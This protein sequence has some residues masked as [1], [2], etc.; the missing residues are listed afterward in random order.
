MKALLLF[1]LIACSMQVNAQYLESN[2]YIK[3]SA[4]FAQDFPGLNGYGFSGE[5]SLPLKDRL[6]GAIGLR[7]L[8]MQGFPRTS[9][10]QEF[11]KA[12]SIDFNL[13]YLPLRTDQH[14][15][16]VG[17]GYSFVVYKTR[18]SY[19][20]MN[21]GTDKETQWPVKDLN[22]RGSGLSLLGE[23]EYRLANG[24]LSLGLRAAWVKAYD[25]AFY[26][27]PFAAIAL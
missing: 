10:V 8:Q 18:R 7:H 24:P 2:R 4:G 15:L 17:A 23:Y 5:F 1:L 9:T 6:E 11:T 13:Y 3:I 26:F 20:V 22:G 19:P 21:A 14:I 27:G 25:R 16:R 12:S